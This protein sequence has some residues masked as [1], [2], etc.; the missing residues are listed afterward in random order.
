MPSAEQLT[1]LLDAAEGALRWRPR[2]FKAGRLENEGDDEAWAALVAAASR[3][4]VERNN[5][6]LTLRRYSDVCIVAAVEMRRDE[7]QGEFAYNDSGYRLRWL[8]D[9]VGWYLIACEMIW[10]I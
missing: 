8:R 10:V 1:D 6:D 2:G 3:D 7:A 4:W 9:E 5:I